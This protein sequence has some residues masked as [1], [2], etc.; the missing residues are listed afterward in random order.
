MI[1]PRVISII[2]FASAFVSSISVAGEIFDSPGPGYR[3]QI[4]R[5]FSSRVKDVA[6]DF[7]VGRPVIHVVTSSF[8]SVDLPT[9]FPS[10]KLLDANDSTLA[11]SPSILGAFSQPIR[12]FNR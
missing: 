5:A 10:S 3:Q 7:C 12:L 4:E 1:K 11:L 8:P 2:G 6:P 9:P